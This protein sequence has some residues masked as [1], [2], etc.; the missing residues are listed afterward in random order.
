LVYERCP[1]RLI[2]VAPRFGMMRDI[3]ASE[4]MPARL[5]EWSPHAQQN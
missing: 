2:I 1:C 3:G 5:G 4:V